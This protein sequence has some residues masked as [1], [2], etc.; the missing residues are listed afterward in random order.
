MRKK[1]RDFFP[2]FSRMR[3]EKNAGFFSRTNPAI[4]WKKCGIFFPHDWC[5]FPANDFP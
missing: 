5:I 3:A 2:H 1:M 4:V